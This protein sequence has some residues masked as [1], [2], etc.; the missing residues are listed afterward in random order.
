[1]NKKVMLIIL[2]TAMSLSGKATAMAAETASTAAPA[3]EEIQEGDLP[4]DDEADGPSVSGFDVQAADISKE[5]PEILEKETDAPAKVLEET[6]T[7]DGISEEPNDGEEAPEPADTGMSV[8]EEDEEMTSES[9]PAK[10]AAAS[11]NVQTGF[12]TKKGNK[13]YYKN[14]V[15]L[16]D[17]VYTI[18]GK[19]YLF[20][21]NGVLLTGENKYNGSHYVSDAA[22]VLQTG[23]WIS[24]GGKVRR[25]DSD[26]RIIKGW[27]TINGNRYHFS[28]YGTMHTGWQTINGKRYCFT[29]KGILRTGWI[30]VAG[31]RYH[32][33]AD[34]V[35]QTGWGT[36]GGKKYYFGEDGVMRT[37]WQTISGR[38]YYFGSNGVRR[39]GHTKISGKWYLFNER[40]VQLK[41]GAKTVNKKVYVVD[42]KGICRMGCFTYGGKI[43]CTSS[44]TPVVYKDY[45][46]TSR[47]INALDA[48]VK[49]EA[50]NILRKVIRWREEGSGKK[51]EDRT[52]DIAPL[53]RYVHVN[54]A[55]K[56][57]KQI[58]N[59]VEKTYLSNKQYWNKG[60]WLGA[61][62]ISIDTKTGNQKVTFTVSRAG[63]LAHYLT[64]FQ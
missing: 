34:G 25:T 1:M 30:T 52:I 44:K 63:Q 31:K 39:T 33:R 59:A 58:M 26:G 41:N 16:K 2:A 11:S 32:L 15:M 55:L 21:E 20:N 51:D 13:Y 35:M 27:A 64:G 49:K 7:E 28:G 46:G 62:I 17:G 10:G 48:P 23:K 54:P 42:S 8:A 18:R 4:Q 24:K 9:R 56:H 53:G 43:Y 19:K 60:Q 29:D 37:G 40:G 50:I 22:G 47:Y 14:G 36:V 61:Y 6:G 45:I 38:K 3:A 12:I 5:E 57:A